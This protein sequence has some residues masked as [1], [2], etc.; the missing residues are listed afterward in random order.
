MAF[1]SFGDKP[2][3]QAAKKEEEATELD[4]SYFRAALANEKRRRRRESHNAVERRRRDNI[5]EKISELATLI[6]ECLLD[7]AVNASG[8]PA[9]SNNKEMGMEVFTTMGSVAG[10]DDSKEPPAIKANKG[11]ILRKSVDYIRYLQQLV[12]AQA[13]RN[14]DLEAQVQSLQA[15]GVA[16]GSSSI[17]SPH[18]SD[19]APELVPHG[20]THNFHVFG[21][22][23][24]GGLNGMGM[25]DILHSLGPDEG[26]VYMSGQYNGTG[27]RKS[28][29]AQRFEGLETLH[30]HEQNGDTRHVYDD[31]DNDNE[32][33]MELDDTS[34]SASADSPE[35]PQVAEKEELE[36]G[37]ARI[38]PRM[39]D[40]IE[41]EEVAV[42]KES[43]LDS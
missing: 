29:Q 34:P 15:R 14:R 23:L 21:D 7:P 20:Q 39:Q 13:N 27:A 12:T 41:A 1:G 3:I 37:R 26:E 5:N 35:E 19:S 32:G 30:E 33:E 24:I 11:M 22:E 6:P 4:P 16:G 25:V 17:S 2:P 38:R 42:K 36:R 18:S 31:M 10:D 40:S 8:T 43:P 28:P 9:N